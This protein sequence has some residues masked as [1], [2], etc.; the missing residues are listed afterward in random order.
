MSEPARSVPSDARP[1]GVV[2]PISRAATRRCSRPGCP[3]LATATLTFRYDE[4][5]ARL[6]PLV[7]DG[8]P[9]TYDLCGDHAD[10]T[11]PPFGWSLKDDRPEEVPVDTPD[12]A[13]LSSARTV[14][15]LAAALRGGLDPVADEHE[16]AD[17]GH[18]A[19][20]TAA[21]DAIVDRPFDDPSGDLYGT[22][23]E[24]DPA[25]EGFRAPADA[26]SE[27]SALSGHTDASDAADDPT[28]H[29]DPGVIEQVPARTVPGAHRPD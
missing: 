15:V 10:R 9:E 2:R 27:L 24:A 5:H 6:A 22:V 19:V 28:D 8:G 23:D 7:P 17:A 21:L 12:V 25:D 11:R 13:D 29:D 26:L 14:A 4:Q 3:S 1:R 16:V 18:P 20:D